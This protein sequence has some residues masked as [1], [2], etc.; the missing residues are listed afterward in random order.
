MAH[1]IYQPLVTFLLGNALTLR[2]ASHHR[3]LE[4]H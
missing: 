4:T 3:A 1:L 2:L